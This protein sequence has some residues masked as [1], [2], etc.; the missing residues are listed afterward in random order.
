[1]DFLLA[2]QELV[3]LI[4]AR[5]VVAALGFATKNLAPFGEKNVRRWLDRHCCVQACVLMTMA[6]YFH[7]Q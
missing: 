6:P 7:I 2:K 1:M 4:K 5:N 3:E